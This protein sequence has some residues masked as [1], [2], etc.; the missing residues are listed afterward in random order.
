MEKIKK[1][2]SGPPKKSAVAPDGSFTGV[3]TGFA[4]KYGMEAR[5]LQLETT[6]KGE[7]FFLMVEETGRETAKIIEEILPQAILSLPYPKTMRW[8]DGE[9][10]FARP[11]RSILALFGKATL[12][13][14]LGGLAAGN[15][16]RGHRFLSKGLLTVASPE[17]YEAALAKA[18]V[19]VDPARR[20]QS[21]L[22][23]FDELDARLACRVI[24]DGELA[25]EVCH[26]TENPV[27]VDGS[28]K[29][30]Y[31]ALPRELLIIV[32]KRHQRYFPVEDVGGK[33][34]NRFVAFSNI[35]CDDISAVRK[36][37][38]RVLEA[39]LSDARF[40]H[41]EDSKRPLAHFAQK[42][43]GITYQ[44]G[45]GTVADKVARVVNISCTLA[46]AICPTRETEVMA[47]A[48]LCKADLSS[49]MVFE[50][51]ELQ[52]IMGREYAKAQGID[53]VVA[54]AIDQHY[55]PRFSGDVLPETDVAVCVALADNIE[56]IAGCFALEF[57]PTGSEDPFSLR[58]HALGIIR[59]LLDKAPLSLAA[60]IEAGIQCLPDHL[61]PDQTKLRHELMEFFHGRIKNEFEARRGISHDVVDAVLGAGRNERLFFLTNLFKLCD[62]LRAM[63]AEPYAEALSIT[64][65]RAANIVKGQPAS[66]E[67]NEALLTAK[68]EKELYNAYLEVE[69]KV[70]PLKEAKNYMEVLKT[71]AG[72]RSAVDG[73]FDGVM[74]MDKDN[75]R[76]M[77]NRIALL[78]KVTSLFEDMA[79][80]S[81]LVF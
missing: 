39:R 59:I 13:F 62:A 52:G 19:T 17:E 58:R 68:V 32:M 74:V 15:T 47:A 35:N 80:F 79:D 71:I 42:L 8:G 49:Q 61:K 40:F 36:G 3:A 54:D 73:F 16:T 23:Q 10:R 56:T 63:K 81:K 55:R 44:K 70:T 11:I 76:L 5:E 33:L 27:A 14:S 34:T 69:K 9:I 22:R 72:I 7:Y 31:L 21:I 4:K 1:K 43:S 75:P 46:P 26:L 20:K 67:L 53:S 78:R 45:L 37:Y 12:Q 66:T 50:F 29:E 28:F 64:F 6:P 77:D 48:E 51:P 24:R 25:D 30:S 2:L 38:E 57:I 60:I 18:G 41:D 65:R